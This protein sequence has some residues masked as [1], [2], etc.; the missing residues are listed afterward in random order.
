MINYKE[1]RKR[2][3][4]EIED[5][6][7]IYTLAKEKLSNRPLKIK[8]DIEQRDVRISQFNEEDLTVHATTDETF[9]IG[10]DNMLICSA[11][12][13]KYIEIDLEVV[14]TISHGHYLCH[15]KG[16]RRATTG[17]SDI[18]FKI[19][20]GDCY[21]TNFRVSKHSIDVSMFKLPTSIK[22]I[23]DQF[24]VNNKSK[25][26]HIEAGYFDTSDT[27]INHMKKSSKTFMIQNLHDPANFDYDEVNFINPANLLASEVNSYIVQ[28]REK[29]F[30]SIMIVPI[31][32]ITANDQSIP[33]AYIK[34]LSKEQQLTLDDFMTIKEQSFALIDRIR[35]SNTQFIEKKQ[36]IIDI[37]KGGARLRIDDPD[38]KK[39]LIK[40]RG[41]VL[42]IVFKLQQPITI[43]GEIKFTGADDNKD[44]LLG[45]SFSGNTS[46]KNQMQHLYGVLK[47][48]ELQ[49]KKKLLEQIKQRKGL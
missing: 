38:L 13:D 49:Y 21:A 15:F 26:D 24:I 23:I 19:R 27:V 44:L 4:E 6:K 32:Y 9:T 1:R 22:V 46:R 17:R 28:N 47:P 7:D 30:K 3:F 34:V 37:S 8:Y 43:Y 25:Y 14:E 41:F 36:Q 10:T 20:P 45:L 12:L 35:N 42:D 39:Y 2:F 48:M 16:G 18:R 40:S 11:L 29:G 31:I 5:V 33:F